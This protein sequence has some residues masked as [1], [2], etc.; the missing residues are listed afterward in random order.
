MPRSSAGCAGPSSSTTFGS[1]DGRSSS[2]SSAS[3]PGRSG[4][5]GQQAPCRSCGQPRGH[6]HQPAVGPAEPHRHPRRAQAP[7]TPVPR[8]RVRD[9]PPVRRC[10]RSPPR[11]LWLRYSWTTRPPVGPGRIQVRSRWGRTGA[12]DLVKRSY[13]EPQWSNNMGRSWRTRRSPCS[14]CP[15]FRSVGSTRAKGILLADEPFIRHALVEGDWKTHHKFFHRNRALL[16]EVEE[17]E[18]RMRRRDIL[19]DDETLFAFYDAR[20]GPDVV[21]ERHFD[22]WSR[23]GSSIRTCS[24]S[25]SRC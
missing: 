14:A 18:A 16:H 10:S 17:L 12:P 22:K 21:S 3:W 6:R 8:Q 19:V 4:S 9:L 20:I 5:P 24:T 25:T 2:H 1:G 15:S 7:S 23:L 13:S 11:L